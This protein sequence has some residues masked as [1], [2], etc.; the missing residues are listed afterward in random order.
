MSLSEAHCG[1]QS[2][3]TRAPTP[4]LCC[5]SLRVS[6]RWRGLQRGLH[7]NLS[8]TGQCQVGSAVRPVCRAEQECIPVLISG[9][10]RPKEKQ[11]S[12]PKDTDASSRE[13]VLSCPALVGRFKAA[14]QIPN[15]SVWHGACDL[16]HVS[17][18]LPFTSLLTH[19][20]IVLIQNSDRAPASSGMTSSS[21]GLKQGVRL[22]WRDP[23]FKNVQI[24]YVQ[25]LL[26]CNLL[27][28]S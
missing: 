8:G 24:P 7:Q 13:S 18:L 11:T 23:R 10:G 27:R 19:I 4:Y 15:D 6:V 5:T 9:E 2:E 20:W 12:A 28:H 26:Q 16:R 25:L 1:V 17:L 22:F 21:R 14:G 3:D